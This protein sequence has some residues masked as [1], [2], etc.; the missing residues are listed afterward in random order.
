MKTKDISIPIMV[1]GNLV[2]NINLNNSYYKMRIKAP[3]I[4]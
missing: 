3:Q 4:A 2:E 1:K